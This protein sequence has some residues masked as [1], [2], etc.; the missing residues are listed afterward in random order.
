LYPSV[1]GSVYQ[2]LDDRPLSDP[3]CD[4]PLYEFPEPY[5]DD[6]EPYDD[7]LEP[8]LADSPPRPSGTVYAGW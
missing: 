5:D 1:A 3:P 6:P 2:S 4:P 8:L 7:P